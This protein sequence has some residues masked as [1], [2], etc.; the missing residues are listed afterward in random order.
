ML[1][2]L[3]FI[4][5]LGV[6][7]NEL[8]IRGNWD[9]VIIRTVDLLPDEG[10][11]EVD[12]TKDLI[13]YGLEI[14]PFPIVDAHPN[15]SLL[16][17]KLPQKL[18]PWVHHGQPGRVLEVVVVMLE[19]AAGVVG[20][21]DVDAL[22]TTGI[23]GEEGLEG[24]EVVALDEEVVS[25]RIRIA[26]DAPCDGSVRLEEAERDKGGC[27]ESIFFAGPGQGGH[28]CNPLNMTVNAEL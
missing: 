22:H 26:D 8:M 19:G 7:K 18:E 3:G 4:P 15:A 6:A 2:E 11:N 17:E 10:S 21:I 24:F 13:H 28:G 23:V 14:V 5:G 9:L 27:A 16:G 1:L 25:L 20:R 12:P